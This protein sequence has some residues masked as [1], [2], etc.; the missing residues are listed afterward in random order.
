MKNIKHKLKKTYLKLLRAECKRKWDKAR[1]L[2]AKII[3][4]ELEMN[5]ERQNKGDA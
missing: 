1:N 2:H 5:L 3:A 4:L